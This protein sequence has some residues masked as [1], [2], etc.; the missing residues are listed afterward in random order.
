VDQEAT[1]K[2]YL[3]GGLADNMPDR[4]FDKRQVKAGMKVEAEHTNRRAYQ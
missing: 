2:D 4:M 1:M 3:K